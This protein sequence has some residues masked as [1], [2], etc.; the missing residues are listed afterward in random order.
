MY[1]FST[2][3]ITGL[4]M[5]LVLLSS[6]A[7]SS[8]TPVLLVSVTGNE[9]SIVKYPNDTYQIFIEGVER[10]ASVVKENTTISIPIQYVLPNKT[11]NAGIRLTQADENEQ[12]VMV[13]VTN[14][15]YSKEEQSLH[16]DILPLLF[17]EGT[18]LTKDATNARELR[19]GEYNLTNITIEIPLSPE[20]NPKS[21]Y[22]C[23]FLE[24]QDSGCDNRVCGI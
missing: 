10:N 20:E 13:Q 8:E 21:K 6:T 18:L 7:V 19:V 5:V 12:I 22:C 4:V 24:F 11:C 16:L 14:H 23:D 2:L 15:T 17:Y 9:S 3:F 1:R